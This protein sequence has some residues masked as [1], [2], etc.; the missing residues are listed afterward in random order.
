MAHRISP[1][2]AVVR[3]WARLHL[4]SNS[5]KG[6]LRTRLLRGEAGAAL[7]ELA[8][9]TPLFLVLLLGAYDFGR[10][11]YLEMDIASAAQAGALY[12][13]QNPSD[14]T[15]ITTVV[16]DNKPSVSDLTLNAPTVA[17]GCECPDGSNYAAGTGSCPSQ[18]TC[19]G[20][21][22]VCRVDVTVTGTYK[23][24]FP[25]PGVPSSMTV[26]NK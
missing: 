8:F 9:L 24:I 25:W 10:I 22:S 12:G 19:S 6:P 13:S 5:M 17:Y 16:N 15:G 23:P 1:G 26:S 18:S 3:S 20:A 21:I 11:F 14:T 2:P 4:R 7:I